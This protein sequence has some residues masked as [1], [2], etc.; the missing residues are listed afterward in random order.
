MVAVSTR[1]LKVGDPVREAVTRVPASAVTPTV[2]TPVK[3]SY[4][5]VGSDCRWWWWESL[6]REVTV[7][8]RVWFWWLTRIRSGGHMG[9]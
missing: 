4:N 8:I 6:T 7:T 1:E 9:E 2:R 3:G 5:D